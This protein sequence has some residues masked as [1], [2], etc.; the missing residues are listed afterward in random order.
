MDSKLSI[1]GGDAVHAPFTR[2]RHGG[3]IRNRSKT[4]R[5]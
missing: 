2:W 4:T 3:A 5:G 1:V